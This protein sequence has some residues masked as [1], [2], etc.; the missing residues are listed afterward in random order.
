MSKYVGFCVMSCWCAFTHTVLWI[1]TTLISAF[2]GMSM[3]MLYVMTT[4]TF[5]SFPKWM[6]AIPHA[7]HIWTNTSPK[8]STRLECNIGF[9]FWWFVGARLVIVSCFQNGTVVSFR[10][11]IIC[12]KFVFG[13]GDL[14]LNCQFLGSDFM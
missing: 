11:C 13:Q 12:C 7:D 2:S 6:F 9:N 4:Y 5:V 3:Y 14:I 10:N 8:F 1:F